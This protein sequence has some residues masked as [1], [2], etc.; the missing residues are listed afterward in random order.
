MCIYVCTGVH[1][2]QDMHVCV[3]RFVFGGRPDF[4]FKYFP[5]HS[6]LFFQIGSLSNLKLN[7][8]LRMP[9]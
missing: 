9:I 3:H 7:D 6:P 2:G 4:D 8:S 1:V 5:Q